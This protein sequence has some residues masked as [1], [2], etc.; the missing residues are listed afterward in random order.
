MPE[1][2]KNGQFRGTAIAAALETLN[3]PYP[4]FSRIEMANLIP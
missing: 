3:I 1:R 4:G 2:E